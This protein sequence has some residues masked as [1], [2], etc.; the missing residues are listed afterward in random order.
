MC[1]LTWELVGAIVGAGLASGREIASFFARYG[2]WGYA[3][4]ILS[5]GVLICL[6]DTKIPD[7]W[8]G[9]WM[10]RGWSLLLTLLLVVTGGAMLSGAGEIAALTIPIRGAYLLGVFATLALSWLLANQTVS[11]LAWVSRI[12]LVILAVLIV[13]G[14]T[15]PPIK[16]VSIE[17]ISVPEALI[18]G[19]TYGGFNAA[20]QAPIMVT[21]VRS[22]NAERK[23]AACLAGMLILFLLTLGNAVILRHS[24]TISEPMPFLKI[25]AGYGKSGY[26]LCSVSLYL[27]ILSTLTACMRGIDGKILP[28]ASILLVSMFG[29]TGVVE[30]A[31]PI[32]GGGCF[33]MLL[34]AKMMNSLTASFHSSKDML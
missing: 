12:L 9:K 14:L 8:R 10:E 20:L 3:G 29:F 11:G 7:V 15:L 6:A 4:I 21:A 13:S 22:T 27:A 19:L 23:R 2:R 28:A 5:V 34:A 33:L 26:Y 17:E 25:M 30:V 18:R 24:A 32:L 31:Y 1:L 16:A